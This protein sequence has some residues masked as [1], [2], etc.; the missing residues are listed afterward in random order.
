MNEFGKTLFF[1]GL[2]LAVVGL[3]LWSGI[4]RTWIGRL[5]GDVRFRRGHF[6][7]YFPVVTC[8]VLSGL[9]TMLAWLLRGR[10]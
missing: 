2:G 1:L 7:F 6:E 9:L 3:V 4:G 10:R 8:L 5:P